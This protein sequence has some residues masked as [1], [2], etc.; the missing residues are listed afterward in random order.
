MRL[1]GV[2][3]NFT[4][5]PHVSDPNSGGTVLREP[6]GKVAIEM[7]SYAARNV[8]GKI[9]LSGKRSVRGILGRSKIESIS[10][11][12][13]AEKFRTLRLERG[14]TL[15][16]LGSGD[17]TTFI[18]TARRF[19]ESRFVGVDTDSSSAVYEGVRTGRFNEMPAN[20]TY[21]CV[22]TDTWPQDSGLV[23][24]PTLSRS[25][26]PLEEKYGDVLGFLLGEM[27]EKSADVVTW[28]YPQMGRH[29]S[30]EFWEILAAPISVFI[31][32]PKLFTGPGERLLQAGIALMKSGGE[33][34][35]VIEKCDL[36][37]ALEILR[38]TP[39]IVT[40][41]AS[42]EPVSYDVLESLGIKPYRAQGESRGFDT[43]YMVFIKRV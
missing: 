3:A 38:R 12:Q 11:E 37:S 41:Q 18:N 40:V 2:S 21:F 24:V 8:A 19:P 42:S 34:I 35:A 26:G 39:E 7:A 6:R 36:P 15:A 17:G 23:H 30:M 31:A 22:G 20:A 32:K 9:L 16:D 10:P 25:Q 14:Q 1:F 13:A 27:G 33:G 28:F 5:V 29:T 4:R 43:S